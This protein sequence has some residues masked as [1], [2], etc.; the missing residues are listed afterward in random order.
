MIERT[1]VLLKP[2]A[3]QRSLCG[4]IL[5]RFEDAGIKIVGMKMVWIDD[6]FAKTHYTGI[7]ERHGER[8]LKNLVDYIKEAPVVALVLEGVNV[9]DVVR[10]IVGS[11]YPNE[12]LPGTI[13]GDFCHISKKYANDNN[14]KVGNLIHASE[15][16]KSAEREISLWFSKSEL[17]N[18]KIVH[19]IHVI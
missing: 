17:F 12:S 7:A 4:R 8:V 6:K 15:D 16:K 14:K 11:T 13:R 18:Y 3:V 2:D 10:K 5:S 9:I 19:D 1:L